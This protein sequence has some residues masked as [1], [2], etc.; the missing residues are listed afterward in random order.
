MTHFINVRTKLNVWGKDEGEAKPIKYLIYHLECQYYV[1][2]IS[3]RK[4][5]GESL[6]G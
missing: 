3:L 4:K 6:H 5:W 2:N 1:F